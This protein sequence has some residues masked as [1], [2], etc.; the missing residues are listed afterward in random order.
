M[1]VKSPHPDDPRALIDE[2][3]RIEGLW[4]EDARSIF[5]DWALGLPTGEDPAAAASRLLAHH[6][7]QPAEHP[8]SVLLREAAAGQGARPRRRGGRAARTVG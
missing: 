4:P 5:F 3:Y 1:P 8:M 2:A 6:G 7:A